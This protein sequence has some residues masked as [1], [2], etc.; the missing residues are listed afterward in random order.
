M[1]L[2]FIKTT[3]LNVKLRC[4]IQ[5]TGKLGFTETT[6]NALK[7]PGNE[8]F[9]KFAQDTDD[10]NQLYM[11]FVSAEDEGS[12]KVRKAGTYYYLPTQ[13]LF[14]AL[15]YD[16]KKHNYI[17]DLVRMANLDEEAQGEVYKMKQR[18]LTRKEKK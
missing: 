16:Y 10:N 14:D 18:E 1:K 8:R 7:L 15:G 17:F 2:T 13:A 12:F 3:E 6:A 11:V 4:T 9:V 5:A